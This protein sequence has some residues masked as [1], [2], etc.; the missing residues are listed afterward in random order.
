MAKIDAI[1][2]NATSGSISCCSGEAGFDPYQTTRLSRYDAAS[3]LGTNMKRREF[4]SGLGGAAA[5][6]IAVRAQQPALPVVMLISGQGPEGEAQSGPA[7]IN[8]LNETGYIVDRNVTL[9][10]HWL[11]GDYD[12][13]K[14]LIADAVRRNVAVI[15]TPGLTPAAVAAKAMTATIPIVFGV[16]ADPVALG[17]VSSLSRP[18]GNA[19]GINFFARELVGKR[20]RLLHDLLPKAAHVAVL[21]NQANT[22]IAA[23]TVADANQAASAMG[24]QIESASATTSEEIAAVFAG[25]ARERPDAVLL[26][27]DAF[28]ASRVSQIVTLAAGSQLPLAYSD[29][30]YVKSGGLMSYGTDILDM[31][32]QCGIYTGRIL[33]GEKPSDLPVLQPTKFQF[34]INMQTARSLGIDVPNGM[35]SIADE[36]IE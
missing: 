11:A 5:W 36:V 22:S 27:P 3:G 33:K 30:R 8:G 25:F 18:G 35:L 24:L 16:A 1:D 32:R 17:I 28:F 26:A 13:M 7:Y 10:Q 19:T 34:A 15:T 2:P 21:V 29:I 4:L 20:L 14:A 12:Q 6:P 9:E 23:T 31:F